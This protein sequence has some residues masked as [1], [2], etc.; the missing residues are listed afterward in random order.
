VEDSESISTAR[1]TMVVSEFTN[2]FILGANVSVSMRTNGMNLE[3]IPIGISVRS[4]DSVLNEGV[5][6]GSDPETSW[7]LISV[8]SRPRSLDLDD[9]VSNQLILL[10][11]GILNEDVVTLDRVTNVVHNS[12]VVSTMESKGSVETGVNSIALG[13]RVVYGT[14]HVEMYSVSTDFETL[15]DILKLDISNSAS[16]RVIT[17]GMQEDV[18][19]ILI[20][21]GGFGISSESNVSGE[22][23]NFGSHINGLTTESRHRCMMVVIKW[24]IEGENG[25]VGVGSVNGFDG[26]LL[27]FSTIVVS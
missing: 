17:M 6:R 19:T 25:F 22:E 4:T 8:Q 16:E 10:L 13:V 15:S 3:I 7:G 18:S 12:H 20:E 9:T 2:F 14:N 5:V 1:V 11:N 27:T 23:T 24:D 26:S 21:F